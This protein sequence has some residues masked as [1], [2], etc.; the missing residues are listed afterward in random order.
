SGANTT[1][2][3]VSG[4]AL[5]WT[6]V[7]R[8][9]GQSGTSEIWRAFAPSPLTNVTITATLSQSVVSSITVLSFSG[10]DA[11]GTNGSG[12]IG[13][14]KSASA[15]SGAPTATLTTTRNSSWV[16][17]VG[18]D[19]DNAIARA[20]GANQTV[21]HQFLTSAGDTYW[22]QMQNSTTP[23]SGT[24]VSI[25]DTTPTGDRYNLAIVEVLPGTV[26]NGTP[27]SVAMSSPATSGTVTT[28]ATV[29]A[30]ATD[31]NYAITGVQFLLDGG[32]LGSKVTSAPYSITW[33]SSAVTAGTHTLSAI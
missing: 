1:V 14:T 23:A 17:G 27:P 12:A 30:N 22:V 6:L 9:N 2:T 29:S 33:D 18:S 5:T 15:T 26:T 32:N 13:A 24:S 28:L 16:F 8:A 31:S 25:N 4:A 7:V 20:A 11:T 3:G 10:V 19:F 21:V